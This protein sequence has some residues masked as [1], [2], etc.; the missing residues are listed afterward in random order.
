[1]KANTG[2]SEKNAKEVASILNK[3]LA[4]EFL[5][6]TKTRNYHWNIE[7]PNFMEI[8]K[9]LESQY[10]ALDEIIDEVA[11]RIRKIGHYAQGRL[12]DF[13]QQ[14]ELVEQPYTNDQ[15]KQLK[16]LLEDHETIIRFLRL[17]ID[18]FIDKYK[19]AGSGD[20]ITG[21]LQKHETTAWFLRS[22]LG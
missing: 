19:D 17:H 15:K 21:L 13:I 12:K 7:G 22:Y 16:S 3:I 8:H 18:I 11:E 2:I 1:M 20:F 5:L 14:S 4:D 6:Y 9:I 10:E